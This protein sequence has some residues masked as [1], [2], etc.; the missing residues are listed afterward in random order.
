[1]PGTR[2]L[3]I[4][5]ALGFIALLAACQTSKSSNPLSP[6]VAGPI[7]GVNITAPKLLTPPAGAE[8]D[9]GL[10][11][12][13]LTVENA[14]TT[15]Q[16]PLKYVFEVAA[17]AGFTS[18]VF[19]RDGIEPGDGRTSLKLPDPLA[20]ERTYYWRAQAL[21]GA[22]TGPFAAAVHF[23]V[24]TPRIIDA[25]VVL[26]PTGG[27]VGSLRPV[28]RVRNANRSGPV[29]ALT[30]RFEISTSQAMASFVAVITVPEQVG[31]TGFTLGQDLAYDTLYYWR[32]KA[33]DD[34]TQGAWSSVYSFR[35]PL[36]P[37]I[38]PTPP[39]SP[40]PSPGPPPGGYPSNGPDVVA[41][42]AAKYP[43]YLAAGVSSAQRVSNMEFLRDRIIET[44]ICGGMDLAWNLKRGVGPRSIDAIAW[45]T[46]GHIEVVD[47][48]SDYDNTSRQLQL[49]WV[50]VEGPPGWDPFPA[51]SCK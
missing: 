16:R 41:Y 38:P 14:T 9:T 3:R 4:P 8:I 49:H 18:V 26:Q 50:V 48:A 17:D 7:P 13:T 24:F 36:A 43:S 30:Y 42:V 5:A 22:N 10:Q 34:E 12:L 45:R 23:R 44:G 21:D 20:A 11:P 31:E 37:P 51:P 1:M 27:T 46:G 15:G 2:S 32:V 47:I 39:P 35:T 33:F 6:S 40:G 28:F 25:P 29:A 19:R